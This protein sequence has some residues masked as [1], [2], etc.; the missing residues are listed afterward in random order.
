MSFLFATHKVRLRQK[1]SLI[2]EIPL[3]FNCNLNCIHCSS[4]SPLY[5]EEVADYARLSEDIERLAVIDSIH[6]IIKTIAFTG[7]EPLL[8]PDLI[9]VIELS[10]QCFPNSDIDIQTNGILL[11]QMSEEFWITCQN[12]NVRFLLTNYPIDLDMNSI[13]RIMNKYDLKLDIF[14]GKTKTM[15]R[16][17]L[18]PNGRNDVNANFKRCPK[19]NI[20]P[21]LRD[22]NIYM[23]AAP[24]YVHKLNEYFNQNF[25]VSDKD[26]INIYKINGSD[27]IAKF[28]TKPTPFC[29][30][31]DLKNMKFGIPWDKSCKDLCEWSSG[32]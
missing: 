11:T 32:R 19:S 20:Y 13:N 23:C 29:R 6:N 26:R 25:H 3:A 5:N 24:T 10:K 7:G 15:F 14:G 30:Y 21:K 9:K 1:K 22:G 31:C 18:D 8:Y 28:L 2:L 4:F 16:M 27:D 17:L 12:N